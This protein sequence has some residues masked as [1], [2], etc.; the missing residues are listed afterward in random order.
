MA[1]GHIKKEHEHS[2]QPSTHSE[3]W[4]PKNEHVRL[5]GK[6]SF[7]VGLCDSDRQIELWQAS[8][9][10]EAEEGDV[11]IVARLLRACID[12]LAYF[13]RLDN[14]SSTWNRNKSILRRCESLLK[15][16]ANGHGVW[17]GKLDNVLE[18][19]R[20]LRHTTLCILN[21]LCKTLLDGTSCK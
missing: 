5:F 10:I 6:Q 4:I 1:G 17:T 18:R 7:P 11:G 13:V 20:N 9:R 2:I 15:L 16:W 8:A 12:S 19:S 14:H 21:P 3:A